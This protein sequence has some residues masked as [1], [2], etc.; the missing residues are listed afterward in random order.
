ML[1]GTIKLT[2]EAKAASSLVSFTAG[3]SEFQFFELSSYSVSDAFHHAV[4]SAS[5][6]SPVKVVS[7]TS[8]VWP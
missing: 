1:V 4:G 5:G 8:K 2:S 3:A 6:H 7:G